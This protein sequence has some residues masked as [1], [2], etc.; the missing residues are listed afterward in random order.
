[1]PKVWKHL[2]VGDHVQCY[3]ERRV[4]CATIVSLG[5]VMVRLRT[6]SGAE[7]FAYEHMLFAC[8]EHPQRAT[9]ATS[10]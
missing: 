2:Q 5:T 10:P 3:F 9:E 6:E 1:M 8:E 7:K 4:T